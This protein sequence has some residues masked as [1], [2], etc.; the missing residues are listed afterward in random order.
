MVTR[1]SKSRNKKETWFII[2][3]T[4]LIMKSFA[5]SEYFY[6]VFKKHDKKSFKGIFIDVVIW[7]LITLFFSLG[8]DAIF[9]FSLN[10]SIV[11]YAFL[12]FY[13]D[14]FGLDGGSVYGLAKIFGSR[15]KFDNH[16]SLISFWKL[17]LLFLQVISI[18]LYRKYFLGLVLFYFLILV[19]IAF[20]YF[21]MRILHKLD[22]IR[23]L[24]I[25]VIVLIVL[26]LFI[27]PSEIRAF[28]NAILF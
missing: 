15:A 24:A 19:E 26:I 23:S 18:L 8:L 11:V 17:P 9:G 16:I 21:T 28:I 7:Y 27:T 3:N 20:F 2:Y 4:K 25:S 10:L 14:I 1:K 6:D 12:F 5:V 13:I 22:V